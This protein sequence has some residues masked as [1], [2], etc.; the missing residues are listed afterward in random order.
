MNTLLVQ[1]G[2]Y[3]ANE[4]ELKFRHFAQKRRY[5]RRVSRF[6]STKNPQRTKAT[7]L[8]SRWLGVTGESIAERLLR[9]HNFTNV[10]NLNFQKH[11]SPFADCC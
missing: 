10:Q 5:E 3:S 9:K 4:F 8:P 11:N 7:A 1:K 6:E 2:I